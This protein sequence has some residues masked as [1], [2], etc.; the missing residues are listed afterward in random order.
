M[1]NEERSIAELLDCLEAQTYP[2]ERLEVLI[3]DGESCDASPSIVASFSA[4][5]PWVRLISNPGRC[6]AAA[7]NEG[8]KES[9]HEV[10]LRLDCHSTYA[11]DYIWNS[12]ELL[13]GT[14]DVGVVGG[15]QAATGEGGFQRVLARA[16][17]ER[18]A[19]GDAAYRSSVKAQWTDTVYLGAWRRSTLAEVG[20]FDS[21][22]RI[23]EDYELNIRLREAGYGVLLSPAVRSTYH[24]RNN[25][26]ALA[27]QYRDYGF[28]R[29]RTAIAHPGYLR[30][31]QMAPP[32]LVVGTVLAIGLTPWTR[33][34]LLVPCIYLVALFWASAK[35]AR[36]SRAADLPLFAII[37]STIH[38]TWGIGFIGGLLVWGPKRPILIQRKVTRSG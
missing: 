8:I 37:F 32:V 29:A 21:S 19:S 33:W 3:V 31:R 13:L 22:W 17:A 1:R 30:V 5:H 18:F 12:V 10:I 35:A 23:N 6:A 34:P 38:F 25:L 15:L 28:W 27:K 11:P 26:T 36:E 16:M 7:M 9:S 2:T 24:P 20:G 14:P 4:N